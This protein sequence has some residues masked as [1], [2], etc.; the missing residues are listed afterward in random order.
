MLAKQ[1]KISLESPILYQQGKTNN[2]K[3]KMNNT[4]EKVN[5]MDKLKAFFVKIP[6]FILMCACMV[7]LYLLVN[8]AKLNSNLL[9]QVE[10][11]FESS[12]M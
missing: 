10:K 4:A 3:P 12:G 8:E 5:V 6:L 9:L 2:L 1:E 11:E 7:I